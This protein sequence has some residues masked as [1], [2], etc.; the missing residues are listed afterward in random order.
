MLTPARQ[1]GTPFI[2]PGGMKGWVELMVLL[3]HIQSPIQALTAPSRELYKTLFLDFRFRPRNAQNLLPKI[4]TKWPITLLV[5]QID[6]RCLG[7]P[8]GFRGWLIQWNHAKRRGAN[9]CCHGNENCTKSPISWLVWH[10]CN[11]CIPSK[12]ICH[13]M[14]QS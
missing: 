5:C 14:S 7:L 3:V 2:Y 4:C 8:G 6:R 10:H 12:P 11:Q 9:P 13:Q 1:A